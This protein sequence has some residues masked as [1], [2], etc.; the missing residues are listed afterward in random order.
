M[1]TKPKK[2]VVPAPPKPPTETTTDFALPMTLPITSI[3]IAETP[4][5]PK[6]KAARGASTTAQLSQKRRSSPSITESDK[7]MASTQIC[8][9]N[10]TAGSAPSRQKR[11]QMLKEQQIKN[12]FIISTIKNTAA[13]N[14][15]TEQSDFQVGPC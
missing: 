14:Q 4:N 12:K 13:R 7:S 6:R 10:L 11:H 2:I 15:D 9:S 8:P 3:V 1:P 5:R